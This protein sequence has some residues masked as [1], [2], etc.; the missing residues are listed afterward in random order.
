MSTD[1]RARA[2]RMLGRKIFEEALATATLDLTALIAAVAAVDNAQADTPA[3]MP[4]Q[5]SSVALNLNALLPE[6]FKTVASTPQKSALLAITAGV[7][8]GLL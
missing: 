6:P 1:E 2:A 8:Y 5:G 3:A 7:K 4:N